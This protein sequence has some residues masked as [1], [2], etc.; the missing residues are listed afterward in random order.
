MK[1]I[2]GNFKI[3]DSRKKIFYLMNQS[4]GDILLNSCFAP[5]VN[6]PGM[7]Q[8]KLALRKFAHCLQL[9]A[10]DSPLVFTV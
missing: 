4:S 8:K 1:M 6:V 5:V 2:C 9:I 7:S 10:N 3:Y